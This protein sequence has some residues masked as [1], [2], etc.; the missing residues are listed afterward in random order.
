MADSTEG[1]PTDNAKGTN[2][3][4]AASRSPIGENKGWIRNLILYED[5]QTDY[6]DSMFFTFRPNIVRQQLAATYEK[7][8]VMG[9]SHQYSSFSHT[10]NNVFTFEIYFNALMMMKERARRGKVEGDEQARNDLALISQEIEKSRRF[11]ESLLLPYEE[12]SGTIGSEPPPVLV[13]LP[14]YFTV[15]ARALNL[16]LN[17]T[18][19]DPRGNIKE[20]AINATFEEAPMARITMRDQLAAGTFRTWGI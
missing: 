19:C 2:L 1:K 10:E 7:I 13:F 17:F 20:L 18:D 14:G 3:G 11:L 8:R 5:D 15:R 16:T 6:D 12:P 9:M 4:I